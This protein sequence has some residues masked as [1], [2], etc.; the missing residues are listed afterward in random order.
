M[1]EYYEI[2]N[3]GEGIGGAKW[4]SKIEQRNESTKT[5]L[6]TS[7]ENADPELKTKLEKV[8][9]N[10]CSAV[11][12][13]TI[14]E[15]LSIVSGGMSEVFN[16][17][18]SIIAEKKKKRE[19]ESSLDVPPPTKQTS[20]PKVIVSKPSHRDKEPKIVG[21]ETPEIIRQKT[22]EKQRKIEEYMATEDVFDLNLAKKICQNWQKL[23]GV[24]PST[25]QRID[26][27]LLKI[28]EK[29]I[30]AEKSMLVQLAPHRDESKEILL[31]KKVPEK[32]LPKDIDPKTGKII[33][34][35]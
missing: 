35:F 23:E 11:T 28:N 19:A 10:E 5:S 27:T 34:D 30:P 8:F 17:P 13:K 31:P 26:D 24:L 3:S 9:G 4:Q 18:A 25:L 2:G 33:D 16:D 12:A 21:R 20:P 32:I 7:L 22:E 6:K 29:L 1:H 14:L 15:A